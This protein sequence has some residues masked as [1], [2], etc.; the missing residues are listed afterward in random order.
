MDET[1][2]EQYLADVEPSNEEL[3][4]SF[5]V[6]SWTI[7]YPFAG[8]YSQVSDQEKFHSCLPGLCTQEQRLSSQLV[9]MFV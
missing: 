3:I 7:L 8:C 1:L 4:V 5:V 2:G 6:S 9:L